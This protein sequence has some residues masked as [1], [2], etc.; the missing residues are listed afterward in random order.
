MNLGLPEH[1]CTVGLISNLIAENSLLTSSLVIEKIH[2]ILGVNL[3]KKQIL[4]SDKS[5]IA[6]EFELTTNMQCR[7]NPF[8]ISLKIGKSDWIIR[9][10]SEGRRVSTLSFEN[11][12]SLCPDSFNKTA[13]RL[14]VMYKS[15]PYPD[16]P[17]SVTVKKEFGKY[18]TEISLLK[19]VGT[20]TIWTIN[21]ETWEKL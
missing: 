3:V 4:P 7:L 21:L 11:W 19:L 8:N 10:S 5:W 12:A 15:N 1:D 14:K 17:N 6:D 2:N 13:S 18:Q 16:I 20:D 9:N